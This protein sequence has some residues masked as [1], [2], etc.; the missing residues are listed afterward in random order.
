MKIVIAPD[1]FKESLSAL[2]VA[3]H[4]EAGFRQVYP[5]AEY[6][7]LPMADGGEGTVDALVAACNGRRVEVPVTGPEGTPV[8]GFYG[9]LN[10][11]GTAVIEMAAASGLALVP[12]ERRNPL[13]S[14]TWGTGELILAALDAGAH[15]LIIGLG[16]SATSD[17]GAGM[18]QAL[19]ARLLD[20]N[21]RQVS[22]GAEGLLQ[23]ASIDLNTLDPR[24]SD[25][26]IE[27]ACDVTNPLLGP[28]GAAAIFGPQK[29]ASPAMVRQLESALSH[30][31]SVIESQLGIVVRDKP[32][33]G[34]AGGMGV[35]LQALLG[36]RTRAG[37]EIVIDAVGLDAAISGANLVVT[38][39][40]RID[41]QSVQG[42]TPIGVARIARRHRVPV[43]GI[44]GSLSPDVETVYAYGL[45][46]VF[47]VL[48]RPCL[49][50]DALR[51]AAANVRLTARNVAALHRIGAC[52]HF[53]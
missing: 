4:I 23:L 5:D 25:C 27:V 41:S 7:L 48:I 21:G 14:T 50:E 36:G 51:D 31:A 53:N 20:E 1:S 22:P 15:H 30:Y 46:A 12:P 29:G 6:V 9:C 8:A 42:K 19:G 39:E 3:K 38:G 18:L 52:G 44:A 28:Q 24:L 33:G 11:G 47:S 40:G 34:A 2:Q 10:P 45:D 49:L 32:G 26:L 17:G 43:I 37:V 16:G 13:K 35:A